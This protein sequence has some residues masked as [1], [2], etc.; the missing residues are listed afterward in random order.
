MKLQLAAVCLTAALSVLAVSGCKNRVGSVDSKGSADEYVVTIYAPYNGTTDDCAK[1]SAEASKITEKLIGCKVDLVRN[2][3]VNQ[4]NLALASGEKLDLFYAFPWE[5][6][7]SS[8]AVSNQIIPMDDLLAK[9]APDM[10]QSIS[11][12]DWR[13]VIIDGKKYGVPM[14]KDKAQGRGFLMVK[15]VA[16]EVGFDYSK[17]V[18]YADLDACFKKVKAAHKNMWTVVPNGGTMNHPAWAADIL[19]DGLGV[20]ENCLTDSTKVVNLYDTPSF[21]EY[22]SYMYKWSKEGYMMPDAVNTTEGYDVYINSGIGFGTFSPFKSG[23]EAEETRKCG[24]EMVIAKMYEPHSTT[25]M[26]NAAWCIANNSKN[27][28]KAMQVLN[29]LYTNPE[30]ANLFVNGVEGVHW[31]FAD[32]DKGIIKYADGITA[33]TTGYSVV[34]WAWPNEQITYVWEGDDPDVWKKLGEFNK[35]AHSSPAKGFVWNNEKVLNAVTACNNVVAKY[36]AGLLTGCLDPEKTIPQF[37]KE[38]K[39]AGIDA[40][41]SEKQNQLDAWLKTR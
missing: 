39:A 30:L 29:L 1:I 23:I 25:S 33:A 3:S 18:T 2:V 35:S 11:P 14:N 15:S 22:C 28:G 24:K 12:D 38:L 17:Y 31:E 4:L 7:L 16:D 37:N 19:G 41:I 13:C 5:V 36:E 32:K 20:L 10:L 21:K 40:V 8:M 26:V 27:P 34:G 9:Y 6:S